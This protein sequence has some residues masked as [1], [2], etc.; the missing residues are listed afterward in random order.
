[1]CCRT[2]KTIRIGFIQQSAPMGR[3]LAPP[4]PMPNSGDSD[5]TIA[6]PT[7]AESHISRQQGHVAPG[8][9]MR[10]QLPQIKAGGA[11]TITISLPE[12]LAE[13]KTYG[14]CGARGNYRKTTIRISYCICGV[15]CR[16]VHQRGPLTSFGKEAVGGFVSA[17]RGIGPSLGQ[18]RAKGTCVPWHR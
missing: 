18:G 17:P 9:M 10:L 8:A 2:T 6:I 15:L 5:P 3:R 13:S 16:A 11:E 7:L 12:A 14:T 4:I 1:M